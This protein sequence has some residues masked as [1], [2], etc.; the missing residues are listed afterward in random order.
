[1]RLHL[2]YRAIT[3]QKHFTTHTHLLMSSYNTT[4]CSCHIGGILGTM[5]LVYSL[6]CQ[7]GVKCINMNTT[8]SSD[9]LFPYGGAPD[10]QLWSTAD[11]GLYNQDN[12]K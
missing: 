11:F 7:S 10:S 4:A 6:L 3:S 2:K 12:M 9:G 5:C 8:I 1:M